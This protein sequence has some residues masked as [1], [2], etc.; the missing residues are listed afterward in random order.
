MRRTAVSFAN[1]HR[2]AIEDLPFA[3][4]EWPAERRRAGVRFPILLDVDYRFGRRGKTEGLGRTR[5]LSS[6]G[7]LLE[8]D[9]ALPADA[10]I[11]LQIA[12]PAKLAH[13]VKLALHVRARTLRSEG[14][15]TALAIL[16]HEF[17]TRRATET[18]VAAA[19]ATG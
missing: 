4:E 3:A 12:W 6:G 10:F 15:L 9:R 8:T 13:K 11:E 5:N 2:V 16:K 18:C 7:L 17:R 19:A 14:N 1:S